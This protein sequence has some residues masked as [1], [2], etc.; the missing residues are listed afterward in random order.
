VSELITVLSIDGG[1]LRGIIPARILVEIEKL[2]GRPIC[3]LFDLLAGTSTGGIIALGLTRPDPSGQPEYSAQE[4]YELYT[5]KGKDIFP[6]GFLRELCSLFYNE[7]YPASGIEGVLKTYFQDAPLKDALSEVLIASYDI[8]DSGPL[9]FRSRTLTGEIP[10]P[11]SIDVLDYANQGE[12]A[13]LGVPMWK[14]A[15][16]TTAAPTFF[17]PCE[18][19]KHTLID[20]GVMAN[21]PAILAHVEANSQHADSPLL[22]ISLG[23]GRLEGTNLTYKQTRNWGAAKWLRP[24]FTIL[25][26]GPGQVTHLEME[27]LIPQCEDGEYYRFDPWIPRHLEAMDDIRHIPELEQIADKY[28]QQ[29]KAAL[30]KIS[31][32][33]TQ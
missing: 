1:G 2:T 7:K 24:L 32:L 3:E 13:D 18:L 10:V 8:Q 28:V 9:I 33:L 16:A 23:A 11:T 19:G 26:V 12:E 5:T 25:L 17:E 22:H 27:H 6:R 15:R 14:I 30:E 29:E 31:T 4:V 21:N 20:G